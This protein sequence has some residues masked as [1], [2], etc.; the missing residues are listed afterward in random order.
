MGRGR[1]EHL[2]TYLIS[3]LQLRHPHVASH[4][5]RY[6]ETCAGDISFVSDVGSQYFTRLLF[7]YSY[8][9]LNQRNSAAL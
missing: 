3:V 6:N 8:C 5:E 9:A 2:V 1:L 4:A 7:G